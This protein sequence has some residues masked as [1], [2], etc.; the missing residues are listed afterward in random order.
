[1]VARPQIV[2]S[3][4]DLKRN[5]LCVMVSNAASERVFSMAGHVVNSR[6]ANL[7]SSSVN[8]VLFFNSAVKATNEALKVD[9]NVS[10]F[11][12]FFLKAYVGFEMNH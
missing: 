11:T 6:I 4:S 10:Y 9:Q 1:M 12:V 5:T 3:L 8:D 7:K 2:V